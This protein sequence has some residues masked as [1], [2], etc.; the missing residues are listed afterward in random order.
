[1]A[2]HEDGAADTAVE[3]L[4]EMSNDIMTVNTNIQA[5]GGNG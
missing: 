5:A 1:M 3:R 4:N 2:R